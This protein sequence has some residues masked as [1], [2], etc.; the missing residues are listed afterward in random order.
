MANGTPSSQLGVPGAGWVDVVSRVIVQVGFP[1]VVAG[2]LLW[3]L[4]GRFQ[5]NMMTI[6]MR[7]NSNTDS[8]KILL[9]NET[10]QLAELRAQTLLFKQIAE[11]MQDR[12][13][14]RLDVAP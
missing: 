1:V 14:R 8:V 9:E 6:V 4:L 13:R 2:V 7:M 5:E 11:K 10:Q 12:E 3:F